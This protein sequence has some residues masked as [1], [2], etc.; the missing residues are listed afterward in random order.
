[1]DRAVR[2][3]SI[4]RGIEDAKAGRVISYPPGHFRQEYIDKFGV[5]PEDHEG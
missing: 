4:L 1:M 3:A 5:A 2:N